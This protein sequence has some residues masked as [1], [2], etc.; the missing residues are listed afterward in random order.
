M[1][2]R[3]GKLG[4]VDKNVTKYPRVA[5]YWRDAWCDYDVAEETECVQETL[6]FLVEKTEDIVRVAQTRDSFSVCDVLNIPRGMV[7]RIEK[8]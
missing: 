4:S 5:V 8:L 3:I 6:G 1:A 7:K 2:T